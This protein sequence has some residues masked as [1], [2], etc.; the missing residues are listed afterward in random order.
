MWYYAETV[1]GLKIF[2]SLRAR[3]YNFPFQCISI[4]LTPVFSIGQ[5][6]SPLTTY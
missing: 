4:N 5:L 2:S 6:S 1:P 3:D